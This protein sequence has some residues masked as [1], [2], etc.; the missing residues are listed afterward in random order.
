M[1]IMIRSVFGTD[2][3][4]VARFHPMR[5]RSFIGSTAVHLSVIALLF[6]SPPS[7]D[8]IQ[9]VATT[10]EIQPRL[11]KV[12]L[13]DFRKPLPDVSASQRVGREPKP[14]APKTARRVM[15]ATSPKPKSSQ[16]LI[17]QPVPK[18]EIKQ[19]LPLPDLVARMEIP[20]LPPPPVEK[21]VPEAAP[22]PDLPRPP[23]PFVPPPRSVVS[24]QPL[25]ATLLE[26]PASVAVVV[27]DSSFGNGGSLSK[28]RRRTE[29]LRA[30]RNPRQRQH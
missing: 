20:N 7:R 8:S 24:P 23:R 25:P 5:F 18:L 9:T 13:Y 28:G 2:A 29:C 21:K 4:A 1:R 27:S 12:L 16:Q 30:G 14:R 10:E 6:L 3:A 26:A 17:W 15:I 22:P 19:D 11:R